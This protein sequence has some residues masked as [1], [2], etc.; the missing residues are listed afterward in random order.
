[1]AMMAWRAAPVLTLTI[2]QFL[3]GKTARVVLALA[4][5]PALFAL[6][7]LVRPGDISPRFF[8][9]ETFRN[10]I[11]PTL[12]PIAVLLL[13]TAAFGNE[14]EDRTL[15]YLTLKPIGRWRIVLG[16]WIAVLVVVVPLLLA[17]LVAA[18]LLAARGPVDTASR[19]SNGGDLGPVL[20]AMAAATVAGAILLAAVFVLVSLVIPRALLA[21]MVY[22]FAW[23]SLLGRFLPGVQSVSIRHAADS[24]FIA[25]L[26]D[27][28]VTFA[29]AATLRGALLTVVIVSVVAL[30]LAALRLRSMNLE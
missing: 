24:I 12:L 30:A 5:V 29:G 10:L 27:P 6:I 1:M 25:V 13:A 8:L 21:G 23:E 20:G 26:N 15:P 2:R 9:V 18:T 7:W 19:V 16:K 11:L 28:A 14:L 3:G 17:G 4:L 22:V